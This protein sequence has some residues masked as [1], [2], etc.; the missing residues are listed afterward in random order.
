ML[1]DSNASAWLMKVRVGNW[2]KWPGLGPWELTLAGYPPL[3]NSFWHEP[4]PVQKSD[5]QINQFPVQPHTT[6][7]MHCAHL[8]KI[9]AWSTEPTK[10]IC[11][12]KPYFQ[13]HLLN[14]WIM[15]DF[16]ERVLIVQMWK[17]RPWGDP[18]LVESDGSTVGSHETE[19][20]VWK[21]VQVKG[22]AI[23]PI[24]WSLYVY[25]GQKM[26]KWISQPH[27]IS[28]LQRKMQWYH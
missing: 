12:Q 24:T 13:T 2:H 6:V 11:V 28:V 17:S 21:V 7:C 22:S 5:I 8:V 1:M 4:L 19:S 23:E 10:I 16:V 15:F 3:G 20:V 26:W 18:V 14:E 27:N 9:F 25:V